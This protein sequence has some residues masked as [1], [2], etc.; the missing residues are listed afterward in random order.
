PTSTPQIA[1]IGVD[2]ATYADVSDFPQ[3]LLHPENR[4][5]LSFQLREDGYSDSEHEL[6]PS[7]WKYR[8]MKVAYEREFQTQQKLLQSPA[9][10]GP[11]EPSPV[12][13]DPTSVPTDP[14]AT[15]ADKAAV[16]DPAQEQFTGIVLGIAIGSVR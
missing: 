14:T 13:S 10:E 12:P 6:P 7:G 16:F 2:D 3:Y 4:K 9:K 8:R 5:Q 15:A 1:V 11:P